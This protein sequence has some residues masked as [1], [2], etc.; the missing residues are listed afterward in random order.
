MINPT[1][2]PTVLG[3]EDRRAMLGNPSSEQYRTRVGFSILA[4]GFMLLFWAWGSWF[5]RNWVPVRAQAE[6]LAHRDALENA[7][8][9]QE[10]GAQGA[11]AARTLPFFLLTAL[12]IVLVFSVGGYVLLRVARRHRAAIERKRPPP[13]DTRDLWTMHKLPAEVEDEEYS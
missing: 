13:S 1:L 9:D 8:T 7:E 4:V 3:P 2:A 6:A 5:Y 12:V 10:A 11:R